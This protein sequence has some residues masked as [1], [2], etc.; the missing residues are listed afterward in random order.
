MFQAW[1]QEH[2]IMVSPSIHFTGGEPFLYDRFWDV[3]AYARG[4]GYGVAVMTNGCL[5]TK[6]D[7]QKASASGSI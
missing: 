5:V 6:E 2:G 7:A 3:M 4:K 1:E